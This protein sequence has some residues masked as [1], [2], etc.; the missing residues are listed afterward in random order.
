MAP[1]P[2]PPDSSTARS[3]PA[4]GGC[5]EP[6]R[7]CRPCRARA[8]NTRKEQRGVGTEREAGQRPTTYSREPE[9]GIVRR[10]Q[11]SRLR[12]PLSPMPCVHLACVLPPP[13]SPRQT[14]SHSSSAAQVAVRQP[15]TGPQSVRARTRPSLCQR[16]GIRPPIGRVDSYLT[17]VEAAVSASESRRVTRIADSQTS[18]RVGETCEEIGQRS[19]TAHRRTGWPGRGSEGFRRR[20]HQTPE[21]RAAAESAPDGVR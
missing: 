8:P 19:A 11:R 13:Q 15:V 17:A 20:V 14:I 6:A 18:R 21:A 3:H 5:R 16:A 2:G 1:P 10:P 9:R 7:R 12:V 4:A